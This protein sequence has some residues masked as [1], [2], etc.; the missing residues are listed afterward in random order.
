MVVACVVMVEVCFE[1]F[2]MS[3][4][5]K[6]FSLVTELS[7][8]FIYSSILSIMS[9][10]MLVSEPDGLAATEEGVCASKLVV[11]FT[12]LYLTFNALLSFKDCGFTKQPRFIP[13]A[14]IFPFLNLRV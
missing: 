1:L 2:A 7:I 14:I 11:A 4:Y 8:L 13:R 6:S 12:G 5:K 3:C 9:W 10:V